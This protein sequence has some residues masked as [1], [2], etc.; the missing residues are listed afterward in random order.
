MHVDVWY[1]VCM[2]TWVCAH[3]H[4]C[5]NLDRIVVFPLMKPT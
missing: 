4:V 5:M 3:M 1:C 2:D